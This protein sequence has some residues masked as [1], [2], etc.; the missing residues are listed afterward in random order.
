M[1]ENRKNIIVVGGTVAG[2]TAAVAAVEH[3][4]RVTIVSR[5]QLIRSSDAAVDEGISAVLNGSYG[6]SV[7]QH[8]S[9]TLNAAGSVADEGFVRRV[10]ESVP[11]FVRFLARAGVLFNRTTEGN[12]DQIKMSGH[13]RPRTVRVDD[14]TGQHVVRV[15]EEQVR[16]CEAKDLVERKEYLVPLSTVD[17]EENR[18]RGVVAMRRDNHACLALK[19]D[20]V[21]LADDGY[22]GLYG[23]ARRTPRGLETGSDCMTTIPGLFAAGSCA[24]GVECI[25]V[26]G[27]NALA[28]KLVSGADAGEAACEYIDGL[29]IHADELGESLF[30][31]AC[32]REEKCNKAFLDRTEGENPYVLADEFKAWKD[33]WTKG[34]RDVEALENI[35]VRA[36]NVQLPD[37]SNW[38]NDSLI[39]ARDLK[40]E[41]AKFRMIF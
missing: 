13:A 5:I 26:L 36:E 24:D 12:L 16:C 4:A 9:D 39:F 33:K 41:I 17:D 40:N 35:L 2:M 6:D 3:G 18:C 15:L 29:T 19:A 11:S 7:E 25:K 37:S 23:E 28:A 1:S 20:A 21:I 32:D 34:E 38:W 8:V 22:S 30:E 31:R 14:S 27:G 10:C